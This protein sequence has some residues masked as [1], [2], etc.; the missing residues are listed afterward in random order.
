MSSPSN[1]I[2]PELA[3]SRCNSNRPRVDL[4]QPLSPTSPSDFARRDRQ[5]DAVDRNRVFAPV[6]QPRQS[7]RPIESER[8][9][10]SRRGELLSQSG[11]T[12]QRSAPLERAPGK[13]RRRG[14]GQS[15]VASC[16]PAAHRAPAADFDKSLGLRPAARLGKRTAR[17]R[18]SSRRVVWRGWPCRPAIDGRRA[19][20][21]PGAA[22]AATRQG[23]C[24]RGAVGRLS[25][26][27]A[28]PARRS[29][30]HRA[31]R[32]VANRAD[33]RRGCG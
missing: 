3:S 24:R 14:A 18:R 25:T 33:H 7:A 30:W 21:R 15:P 5:R 27:D 10:A 13:A 28:D 16:L 12:H 31:R 23:P 4:P 29:G 11:D 1:S 26:S 20:A 6:A 22:A 2:S 17:V 9:D 32:Y 8:S 19:P